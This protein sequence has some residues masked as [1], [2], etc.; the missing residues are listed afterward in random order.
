MSKYLCFNLNFLL[1]TL[2]LFS[3][4]REVATF[5]IITFG[6]AEDTTIESKHFPGRY[7]AGDNVTWSW[8][9]A[10]GYWGVVFLDFDLDPGIDGYGDYDQLELSDGDRTPTYHTAR[11]PPVVP[12]T[13][14]GPQL[15]VRF[16]TDTRTGRKDFRGFQ[17]RILYG[18]S[19]SELNRKISLAEVAKEKNRQSSESNK[20]ESRPVHVTTVVTLIVVFALVVIVAVIAFRRSTFRKRL[21]RQSTVSVRTGRAEMLAGMTR[22]PTTPTTP[23][24]PRSPTIPISPTQVAR[25][26]SMGSGSRR[27]SRLVQRSVSQ[28]DWSA[29]TELSLESQERSAQPNDYARSEPTHQT[30]IKCTISHGGGAGGISVSSTITSSSV[31]D[32]RSQHAQAKTEVVPPR[33][34]RKSQSEKVMTSVGATSRG[35]QVLRGKVSCSLSKLST[36]FDDSQEFDGA[37]DFVDTI[38][39]LDP[40]PLE[41]IR[42]KNLLPHN[43]RIPQASPQD[44]VLS[45]DPQSEV[46]FNLSS[47]SPPPLFTQT[48]LDSCYE[49][50][51]ADQ[52]SGAPQ[53]KSSIYANQISI[54]SGENQDNNF[55]LADFEPVSKTRADTYES[56]KAGG[57]EIMTTVQNQALLPAATDLAGDYAFLKQ[58]D[59]DQHDKVM[60][61]KKEHDTSIDTEDI[62]DDALN[63]V[64]PV[65][66]KVQ[67]T[68]RTHRLGSAYDIPPKS[69]DPYDIPPPSYKQAKG[70]DP[71]DIPPPSYKKAKGND[72]Y[73]IPPASSQRS[74]VDDSYD[75]PP[76]SEKAT[77]GDDMYDILPNCDKAPIGDNPYDI[78]PTN[79]SSRC[80]GSN[81]STSAANV[82]LS[83][84]RPRMNLDYVPTAMART[85]AKGDNPYDIPPSGR[86]F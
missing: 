1:K 28:Q 83:R 14:H 50:I 26:S 44:Q 6:K 56:S 16:I 10:S 13:S 63:K 2:T 45:Y 27:P 51:P 79:D 72:P 82:D 61:P 86:R 4:L 41:A 43:L 77:K 81:G 31:P 46:Q 25:S 18:T 30:N 57:S 52:N 37:G 71:Y 59:N 39:H 24:M 85:Q 65:A 84:V 35:D 40:L 15:L 8:S 69:D 5:Q 34:L 78:P 3:Y 75:I 68:G 54:E 60:L 47:I 29:R 73:D 80:N 36:I 64:I 62:F 76:A 33:R 58:P 42:G 9:V 7:P 17:L 22:V 48:S 53:R 11:N 66:S 67:T 20:E 38:D 74:R 23:S 21:R 49:N 32:A 19:E 55:A 12:Y 70:D